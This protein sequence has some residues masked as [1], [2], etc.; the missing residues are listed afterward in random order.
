MQSFPSEL[1]AKANHLLQDGDNENLRIEAA[2][3]EARANRLTTDLA[4]V[5]ADMNSVRAFQ[6]P[7][8]KGMWQLANANFTKERRERESQPRL[9][10]AAHL[11]KLITSETR[12][13]A[14]AVVDAEANL[15][16]E[17]RD[18]LAPLLLALTVYGG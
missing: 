13:L 3:L 6:S 4:R 8:L 2:G 12:Q 16:P 11:A 15:A 1:R 14:Q 10:L 17:S 7:S 5:R 18:R 9:T